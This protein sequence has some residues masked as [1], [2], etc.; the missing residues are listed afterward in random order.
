MSIIIIV[1]KQLLISKGLS[2]LKYT[3]TERIVLVFVSL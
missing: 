1:L 2:D 3:I